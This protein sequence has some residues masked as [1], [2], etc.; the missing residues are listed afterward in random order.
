[1][2]N[3][4]EILD[5]PTNASK[6]QI[7]E[8]YLRKCKTYHPDLHQG[9]A[10]AEAH[11]KL[12]NEAYQ[13]LYDTFRR[14]SYDHKLFELQIEGG[15]A[16]DDSFSLHP[17]SSDQLKKILMLG[18]SLTAFLLLALILV[19]FISPNQP[20]DATAT[21]IHYKSEIKEK[22]R[23]LEFCKA[24]PNLL[25]QEQFHK[26]ISSSSIPSGFTYQLRLYTVK[27][28]TA[29]LYQLIEQSFP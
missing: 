25:S 17:N 13:V 26:V 1:M 24:Y 7:K 18:V 3:Y 16:K 8:A 15:L 2:R 19:H 4:Y 27:R 29:S 5:V 9:A 10:W 12:V 28:D 14:Q 21:P 23:F 11:V 22:T 6:A 20:L